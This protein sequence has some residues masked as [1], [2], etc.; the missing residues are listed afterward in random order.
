MG[1]QAVA[2]AESPVTIY[3]QARPVKYTFP[4]GRFVIEEVKTPWDLYVEGEFFGNHLGDEFHVL[5][6][7]YGAERIFSLRTDS[8]IP[9]CQIITKPLNAPALS[10]IYGARR[11]FHTNNPMTVDGEKLVVL[12]I[13]AKSGRRAADPILGLAKDFYLAMG[14][15][16][17]GSLPTGL[18]YTSKR[19]IKR[20][21]NVVDA[22]VILDIMISANPIKEALD[23][24]AP[25]TVHVQNAE[26]AIYMLGARY[27]NRAFIQC[28]DP[29]VK[30]VVD[31]MENE[32]DDQPY[33]MSLYGRS[34]EA[35]QLQE[36]LKKMYEEAAK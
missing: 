22:N 26:L 15:R 1:H 11:V 5:A 21:R 6:V 12:D 32:R 31:Y 19:D 25:D 23:K 36:R 33:N 14:G 35:R 3:W 30:E 9:Q 7:R 24:M 2:P 16:L 17:D 27:W 34:P 4:G 13:I 20:W 18:I 28:D 10:L 29:F 8:G